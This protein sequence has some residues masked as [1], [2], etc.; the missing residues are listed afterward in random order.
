[1]CIYKSRRSTIFTFRKCAKLN[2]TKCMFMYYVLS[3]VFYIQYMVHILQIFSTAHITAEVVYCTVHYVPCTTMNHVQFIVTTSQW[4]CFI[5][6]TAP[7]SSIAL[8][9]AFFGLALSLPL[10]RVSWPLI[11]RLASSL[12]PW[13]SSTAGGSLGALER[14]RDLGPDLS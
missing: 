14:P 13:T 3:W 7:K 6:R 12:G 9:A 1:M 8:L 5:I 10:R 2:Y 11:K 4:P